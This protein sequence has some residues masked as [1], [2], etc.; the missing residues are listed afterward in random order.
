MRRSV[1]ILLGAAA[2]L[3]ACGNSEELKKLQ[4]SQRALEAKVA[5]LEKKVAAVPPAV[6]AAAR[7]QIDP[8]K[9]YDIPTGKSPVKGPADAPITMVEFSDFQCPF[10]ARATP[11]IDQVL[12]TYPKE[13]KFVYKEFPLPMHPN[14]MPASRAAVAAQR[15]GKYWEMHDKL[16]ANQHALQPDNLKQYAQEIGLDVAK[17]EKDMA[18]PDVQQQINED[19]QLA[20]Q[21]SVRGT[22]TLFLAGKR[23]Q[24]RS[25][26]GIKQMVDEAMKEQ[27]AKQG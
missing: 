25:L 20:R 5:V 6:A 14:A 7:P 11:L 13:V 23:V 1:I 19:M 26:P 17:F 3:A 15:Q 22:P 4:E 2:A 18:S 16:F 27:Q 21:S 24:N 9:V 12:Q 10:C 8:N